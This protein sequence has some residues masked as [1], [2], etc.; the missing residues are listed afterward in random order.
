MGNGESG[1]SHTFLLRFAGQ[2]PG[3]GGIP[4]LRLVAQLVGGAPL[5]L[6][7]SPGAA[8][9]SAV[10]LSDSEPPTPQ[11]R[12]PLL[13]TGFEPRYCVCEVIWGRL[14][15]HGRGT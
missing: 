6:E 15:V 10:R 4:T 9:G 8:W 12:E 13:A 2:L 3:K 7:Q 11:N 1:I 5:A 14:A